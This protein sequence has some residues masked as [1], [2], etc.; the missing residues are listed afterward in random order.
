MYRVGLTGA[1][2][3]GKSTVGRQLAELGATVVDA[4]LLA[5]E[6]M[7]PGSP[8]CARILA[9]FGDGVFAAA[10]AI[11]RAA[12]R[13]IVLRDGEARAR[14]EE[15]V[16]PAV[17]ELRARRL[18]R[19]SSSGE[20]IVIED[21]PLLFEAGLESDFDTIVVVDAPRR[22]RESRARAARDWTARHFAAVEASQL[23][24]SE[25]RRRADRVLCNSGDM[26]Q[27]ESA[28]R[29]LWKEISAA[30]RERRA[31]TPVRAPARA[32]AENG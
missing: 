24:A 17:G 15:I 20:R 19:A 7:R 32:C 6:V 9:V 26:A 28:V 27:L 12:L 3:S 5:R 14:L 10:G 16:H 1:V 18:K 2:A 4:D 30:A 21:I 29:D 11:D 8:A 31:S 23:Q 22:L 25:K 13:R